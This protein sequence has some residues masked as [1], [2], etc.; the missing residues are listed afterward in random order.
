M[1]N[2]EGLYLKVCLGLWYYMVNFVLTVCEG[3]Y[4]HIRWQ[5]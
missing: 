4:G 3:A 2:Y 1:Y 5:S